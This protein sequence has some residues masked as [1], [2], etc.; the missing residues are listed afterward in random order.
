MKRRRFKSHRLEKCDWQLKPGLWWLS[1]RLRFISNANRRPQDNPAALGAKDIRQTPHNW[2]WMSSWE[3]H[4][5]GT[6]ELG[7]G[8]HSAPRPSKLTG[9][10][11]LCCVFKLS[12][13]DFRCNRLAQSSVYIWDPQCHIIYLNMSHTTYLIS[14]LLVT[15]FSFSK[16]DTV[17]LLRAVSL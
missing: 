9:T 11:D 10:E 2:S 7:D 15:Y 6:L 16:K 1:C 8:P 4:V 5:L 12:I 17:V 3:L 13:L 14:S